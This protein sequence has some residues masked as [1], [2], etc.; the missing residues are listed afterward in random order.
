MAPVPTGADMTQNPPPCHLDTPGPDAR[1]GGLTAVSGWVLP[2]DGGGE[3]EVRIDGEPVPAH[4]DWV[5]RPDVAAAFPAHA[6]RTPRPGFEAAVNLSPVEPGGRTISCVARTAEGAWV[7]GERRVTVLPGHPFWARARVARDPAARRE[8]LAVLLDRLACPVC[9][10]GVRPGGDELHCGEGHAFPV[11]DGVPVMVVGEPRYPV[12]EAALDSPPSN[13]PYPPQVLDLLEGAL[14][15]GGVALDLGSGRRRFG[16]DRLVQLE[17]TGYPHAD[18]IN[19]GERLP[20]RDGAFDAV[21]CLAVTEHVLRPW[22]LAG[23]IQRV[24]RPGGTLLVDSAFM[25]PFHGYPH[26]YFNM[27][28]LALKSLF[29]R[30]ELVSLEP[31]AYQHP[32]FALRW[33]LDR[34]LSGIGPDA[35]ARL[36]GMPVGRFL[37]AMNQH[38]AGESGDLADVPLPGATIAELAAGFTLIGCRA[39]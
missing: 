16:A 30:V 33:M 36:A 24:L 13:N 8:K 37:A 4:V 18:V 28:H 29:D 15:G 20:F 19:Q 38:C 5:P 25:Q 21:V 22:V 31:A 2:P 1:V 27:T 23:E 10:T 17:I 32:W 26:H 6:G 12:R 34:L 14:A 35:R 3:I 7:V 11:I 9:G 39:A